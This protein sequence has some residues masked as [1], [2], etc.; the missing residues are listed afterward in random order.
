MKYM[1]YLVLKLSKKLKKNLIKR[2]RK[3]KFKQKLLL[4]N[5]KILEKF[6]PNQNTKNCMEILKK[7]LMNFRV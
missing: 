4:K 7:S 1:K 2:Q 3:Q 6:Y 5:R